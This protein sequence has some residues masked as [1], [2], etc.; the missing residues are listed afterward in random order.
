VGTSSAPAHPGDVL[1]LWATGFGP[2]NPPTP[3]G[4]E[5]TSAPAVATLPA[6]TVGGV[7]VTVLAAVLAPDSAGLY[8]IAIQLPSTVPTGA[9][10]LQ[11][12][13]GGATSPS[14][15]LIYVSAQ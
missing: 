15:T 2:T 1:I 8:Q 14:S 13:V 5:V 7:P 10:A 6:I 11:A 12:S 9:V 4:V 3:A